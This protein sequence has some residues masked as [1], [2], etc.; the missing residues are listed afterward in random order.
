MRTLLAE[1]TQPDSLQGLGHAWDGLGAGTPAR[2]SGRRTLD[3]TV[4][5]GISVA[6][7]N[8]KDTA[9]VVWVWTRPPVGDSKPATILSKVLLPQ[10]EGPS[11]VTNSPGS[12]RSDT[13]V[14]ARVPLG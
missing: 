2:S 12:M 8:T 14:K 1:S 4:A 3:S 11:K 13:G 5:Q 10:P 9:A 7:W 6:S